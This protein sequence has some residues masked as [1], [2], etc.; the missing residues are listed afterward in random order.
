MAGVCVAA[1]GGLLTLTIDG[2]EST[3]VYDQPENHLRP[4]V[5]CAV[6]EGSVCQ[7][8]DAVY[9]GVFWFDEQVAQ[10]P[11]AHKT[12]RRISATTPWWPYRSALP[13]AC[14]TFPS[15]KAATGPGL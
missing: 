8:G 3:T 7:E 14:P 5:G 1:V 4:M 11:E 12:N 13:L 2:L 9:G 15:G 6:G 10:L